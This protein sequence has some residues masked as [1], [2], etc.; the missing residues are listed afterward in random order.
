MTRSTVRF[1]LGCGYLCDATTSDRGLETWMEAQRY[2]TKCDIR[3]ED[4]DRIEDACPACARVF[5]IARKGKYGIS[6]P[7]I[8]SSCE[9]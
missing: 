5:A 9:R 3:W 8:S 6:P 1:C 2:L 7:S 4:L